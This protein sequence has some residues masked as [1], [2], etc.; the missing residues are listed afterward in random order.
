[1]SDEKKRQPQINVD[2]GLGGLFKGL[3][4]LLDMVSE[5]S[6]NEKIE[7]NQ[8]GE[9]KVKGLGEQGRGVY[10]VSI[11]TASDGTPRV[12]RFGNIRKTDTGP[13]VADV[14]EPLVDVFDEAQEMVIVAELPGV[15]E[16]QIQVDLKDDILSIETSGDRHYAK[17]ILLDASVDPASLQQSYTNGILELRLTKV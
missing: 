3:G 16:A 9:F 15:V 4:D 1:V 14:R 8:T 5:L 12:E 7:I 11:R 13:E 2:L 6:D 17:E 10:G